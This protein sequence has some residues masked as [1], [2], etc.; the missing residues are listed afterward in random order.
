MFKLWLRELEEPLIPT[1]LYNKALESASTDHPERAITF[2]SRL[3]MY[4]RRV[5]LFVVAFF[6]LFCGEE[7]VAKTKMTPSNL[8]EFHPVRDR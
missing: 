5:L 2:V 4:N 1:D 8:G 6:K 3:P 7:V